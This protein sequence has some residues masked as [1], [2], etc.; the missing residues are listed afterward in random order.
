MR[1]CRGL[2]QP[3]PAQHLLGSLL[4][5]GSFCVQGFNISVH[6]Q[7]GQGHRRPRQFNRNKNSKELLLQVVVFSQSVSMHLTFAQLLLLIFLLPVLPS[8]LVSNSMLLPVLPY[9][10]YFN[11]FV[12]SLY[13][14]FVTDH[15]LLS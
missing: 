10:Y 3:A 7:Q 11:T 6:V 4:G 5:S 14:R 2:V 9:Y 15:C 8:K 1:Q 12:Q 13:Y